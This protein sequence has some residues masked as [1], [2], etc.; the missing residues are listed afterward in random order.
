MLKLASRI[1]ILTLG[2]A[3]F[4]VGFIFTYFSVKNAE[5]EA[6]NKSGAQC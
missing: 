2:K 5:I 1:A 6:P 4:I 3:Y